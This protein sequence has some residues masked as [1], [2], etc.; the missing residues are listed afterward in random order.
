MPPKLPQSYQQPRERMPQGA[1][2]R[3]QPHLGLPEA[4]SLDVAALPPPRTS[5][6]VLGFRGGRGRSDV[7]LEECR[8][9]PSFLASFGGVGEFGFGYLP[10]WF[11]RLTVVS[12]SPVVSSPVLP[13]I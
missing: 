4:V 13:G 7:G 3:P 6:F 10:C 11:T 5:V 1:R 2:Q 9:S 8:V 12:W